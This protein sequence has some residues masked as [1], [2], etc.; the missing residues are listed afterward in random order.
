L[1][2]QAHHSKQTSPA[3]FLVSFTAFERTHHHTDIN[4]LNYFKAMT[5]INVTITRITAQVA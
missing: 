1:A 2:D 4:T 3:I 5:T